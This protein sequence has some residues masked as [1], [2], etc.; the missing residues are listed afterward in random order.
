MSAPGAGAGAGASASARASVG[1]RASVRARTSASAQRPCQR[2][3]GVV[4][5]AIRVLADPNDPRADDITGDFA[6]GW[7]CI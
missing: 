3:D 5:L 1:A 7:E 2:P 6:E 4:C